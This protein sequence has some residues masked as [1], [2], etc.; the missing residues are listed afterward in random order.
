M[1]YRGGHGV[2][3]ERALRAVSSLHQ[4]AAAGLIYRSGVRVALVGRP[5]VGKSSL[6]NAL[7]RTARAIVTEVAGATRDTVEEG[8]IIEGIP[9][10][11]IDTAGIRVTDDPVERIGVERSRA[12]LESALVRVIVID[13]SAPLT[14]D[15]LALLA[16][17]TS[18]REIF[19]LNKSDLPDRSR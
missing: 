12:A 2:P 19:A 13:R 16:E 6:L 17:H 10:V 11:L 9:M 8:A 1:T 7:L 14:A 15:D 3:I 4:R 5:N 18:N